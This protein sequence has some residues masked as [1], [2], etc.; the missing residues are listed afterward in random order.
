[1]FLLSI[2]TSKK[3]YTSYM[4]IINYI[5]MWNSYYSL[6]NDQSL[7]ETLFFTLQIYCQKFYKITI[8][9][10]KYRIS[11]WHFILM[12]KFVK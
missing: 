11:N 9:K 8:D 4:H 5:F 2:Y 6:E 12:E 1:M 7:V 10:N 3:F